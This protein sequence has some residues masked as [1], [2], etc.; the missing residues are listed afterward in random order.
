[1]AVYPPNY[2]NADVQTF[3][4][5]KATASKLTGDINHDFR[6]ALGESLS[7]TDAQI[8]GFSID[9][10]WKRYLINKYT[11]HI[12]QSSEAYGID[13]DVLAVSNP[14]AVGTVL[15][16]PFDGVDQATTAVDQSDYANVVTFLAGAEITTSNSKFGDSSLNCQDGAGDAVSVATGAEMDFGTGEF[17]IEAHVYFDSTSAT[18]GIVSKYT[19][20]SGDKCFILRQSGT[21]LDFLWY[22][23]SQATLNHTRVTS[24]S[25]N[26][27]YHLLV[28]RVGDNLYTFVDGVMQGAATAMTAGIELHHN[29]AIP[30][31]I[32]AYN[33]ATPSSEF[34]G[35]IDNV[36]IRVGSGV[37]VSSNFTPPS[38]PF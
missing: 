34:A 3:I 30:V 5:A 27:W 4:T 31:L 19:S 14:L 38:A 22:P 7:L 18:R 23:D 9:D 21:S 6:Q 1:M 10:L 12:G 24:P 29:A 37:G 26:T 25:L 13:S 8:H 16:L 32:G 2:N 36:R 28:S 15:Q 17:S 35:E 11:V 20:T 33:S